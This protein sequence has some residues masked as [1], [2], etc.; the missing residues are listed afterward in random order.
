MNYKNCIPYFKKISVIFVETDLNE[1]SSVY[2]K[3][4]ANSFEFVLKIL[5]LHIA[6]TYVPNKIS[7]ITQV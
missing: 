5:N 3:L 7:G 4:T 1:L 6:L 2:I